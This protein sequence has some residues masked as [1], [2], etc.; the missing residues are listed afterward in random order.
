[1]DQSK[2]LWE[3]LKASGHIDARG[4]VLYASPARGIRLPDD[5]RDAVIEYLIN[6]ADG[7]FEDWRKENPTADAL[8]YPLELDRMNRSGA[9]FDG[10]KEGA[11]G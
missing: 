7:R 2:A 4:K 1:M 11:E 8:A 10:D 5:P 9:L 3:H 6:L